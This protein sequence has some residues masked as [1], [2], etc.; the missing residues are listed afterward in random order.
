MTFTETIAMVAEE[1]KFWKGFVQTERFLEG[2]VPDQ[3][4][5]ELQP[6]IQDMIE[7]YLPTAS[8]LDVGSGAVSI[9]RGFVDSLYLTACDPL[10]PLYQLVFDYRRY[11]LTPP[12]PLAG[13]DLPFKEKFDIA[14]IS[15]ALDHSQNPK[16]VIH[17]MMRAVKP[18][19]M[20]IVC[21]FVKEGTSASGRGMHR[22]DVF[23]SGSDSS[24]LTIQP[25]GKPIDLILHGE[26]HGVKR[27]PQGRE[28]MWWGKVI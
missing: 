27:T 18:G 12:Q 9:L 16:E 17:R 28:W 3:L 21:G 6:E 2:W 26:I 1:L 8:V 11:G 4:T 19:G 24:C 20:V 22:N 15:N 25:L 23:L 14:H 5:P 7:Q 10:A 13:E